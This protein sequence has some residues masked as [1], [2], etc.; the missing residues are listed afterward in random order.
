MDTLESGGRVANVVN[1]RKY[2]K[3]NKK[4]LTKGKKMQ[5]RYRY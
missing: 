2:R 3:F 1:L 5:P 4:H